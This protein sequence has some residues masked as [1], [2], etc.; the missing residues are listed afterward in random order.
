MI[1]ILCFIGIN[2]IYEI[3]NLGKERKTDGKLKIDH[4]HVSVC[5]IC[6]FVDV[7]YALDFMAVFIIGVRAKRAR[8]YQG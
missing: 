4:S 7:L 5:H 6:G 2:W 1:N 8:H 3:F